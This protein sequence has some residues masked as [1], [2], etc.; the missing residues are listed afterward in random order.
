MSA[1]QI[2]PKSEGRDQ[3]TSLLRSFLLAKSREAYRF[4]RESIVTVRRPNSVFAAIGVSFLSAQWLELR[5]FCWEVLAKI[6]S[7]RGYS[8]NFVQQMPP[9]S[10][11][12]RFG[13]A[14]ALEHRNIIPDEPRAFARITASCGDIPEDV[15]K[16]VR[17][18]A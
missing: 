14:V 6:I 2:T 3:S 11:N 7:P 4:P 5:R 18:R 12:E 8:P 15:R 16:D 9:S 13:N 17:K 10:L 1:S